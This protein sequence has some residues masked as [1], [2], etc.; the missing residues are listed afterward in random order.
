MG[1][2]AY[3]NSDNEVISV[4]VGKNED[5]PTPDG[6]DSWEDYYLTKEPDATSCKRTSYNTQGNQ[7]LN[8]GTAFRGNFASVGM[9]YDPTNDVFY[10][11]TAPFS[12]WTL[13]SNTY[14]YDPPVDYPSDANGG[15]NP[16]TSLPMKVYQW[17][18]TDTQ[19]DLVRQYTYNAESLEWELDES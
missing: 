10:D 6:F 5:D 19:W 3:L 1:H 7:H 8:G 13:N 11:T 12:S 4:I 17:N 9:T 2:Y 16:D 14:L 15:S 18:E